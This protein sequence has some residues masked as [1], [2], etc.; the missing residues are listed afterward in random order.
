MAANDVQ[1]LL[2]ALQGALIHRVM[3]EHARVTKR[4]L[5]ALVDLVLLGAKPRD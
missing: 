2:C 1:Q 3:S 5:L 4:W